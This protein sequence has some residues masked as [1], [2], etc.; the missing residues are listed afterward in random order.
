MC[1]YV[2]KCTCIISQEYNL[3]DSKTPEIGPGRISPS[4][5]PEVGD[6]ELQ[7]LHWCHRNCAG[8]V[9]GIPPQTKSRSPYPRLQLVK[10]KR[11]NILFWS[12]CLII[13][14]CLAVLHKFYSISVA[15]SLLLWAG[16][17]QGWIGSIC[18]VAVPVFPWSA[19][20]AGV[21]VPFSNA[22]WFL[23]NGKG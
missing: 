18:A 5:S 13:I 1:K 22:E 3:F 10:K 12:Y 2:Y 4:S 20:S 7:G 16:V 17:W 14:T 21:L 9:Q 8:C 6:L 19:H 15:F 11:P 23:C